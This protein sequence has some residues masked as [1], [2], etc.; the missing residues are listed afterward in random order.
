MKTTLVFAD[1]LYRLLCRCTVGLLFR[2]HHRRNSRPSHMVGKPL[3][4]LGD[5]LLVLRNLHWS[6]HL[7]VPIDAEDPNVRRLAT[8][9][10]L[11]SP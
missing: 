6:I 2:H 4:L 9:L 5:P 3:I 10:S 1:L 8:P 11:M 7:L